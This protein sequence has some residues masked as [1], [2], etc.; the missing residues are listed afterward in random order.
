MRGLTEKV[1][2]VIYMVGCFA[3]L[4]GVT[5]FIWLL[6]KWSVVWLIAAWNAIGGGVYNRLMIFFGLG[7]TALILG[8]GPYPGK[9]R[10]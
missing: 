5:M 6:T 10:N 4:I 3:A 7:G 8:F 9:D 1:G 2:D